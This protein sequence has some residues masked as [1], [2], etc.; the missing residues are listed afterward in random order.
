M[1]QKTKAKYFWRI[2]FRII[3]IL[4]LLFLFFLTFFSRFYGRGYFHRSMNLL[5]FGT[6][7]QYISGSLPNRIK[8]TNLLGNIEAF[9]PMGFLPPFVFNKSVSFLRAMMICAGI[10]LFIEI[11]QYT[12]AVGAMDVDDLILNLAGG[13]TGYALY[14]L[15]RLFYKKLLRPAVRDR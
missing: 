4:Y 8:V 12:L 7:L 10:S 13:A 14:A 6:I 11:T 3:F 2:A 15:A 1:I 5:P 9:I